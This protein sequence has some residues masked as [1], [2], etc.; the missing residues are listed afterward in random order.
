M[1]SS[2]VIRNTKQEISDASFALLFLASVF[3]ITDEAIGKKSGIRDIG[4]AAGTLGIIAKGVS[5]LYSNSYT[6]DLGAL[7]R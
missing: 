7:F 3:Y 2:N 6:I 1:S 4:I 5:L